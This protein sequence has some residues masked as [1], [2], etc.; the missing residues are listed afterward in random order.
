MQIRQPRECISLL[1]TSC[2]SLPLSFAHI[3][4]AARGRRKTM[5]PANCR[6]HTTEIV[7]TSAARRK[8][9]FRANGASAALKHRS[10][11]HFRQRRRVATHIPRGWAAAEGAGVPSLRKQHTKAPRQQHSTMILPWLF[12]ASIS[13]RCGLPYYCVVITYK[14]CAISHRV[15]PPHE[16]VGGWENEP[17]CNRR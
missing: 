4:G 6:S 15:P 14:G 7:K 16:N 17:P 13:L 12:G 11:V 2:F 10:S 5:H 9:S 1:H 8:R 3:Q